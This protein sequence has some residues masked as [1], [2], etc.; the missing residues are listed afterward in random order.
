MHYAIS[1][2]QEI[3]LNGTVYAVSDDLNWMFSVDQQQLHLHAL[4]P[5]DPFSAEYSIASPNCLMID[6]N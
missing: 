4:D 1:S 6:G 5:D 2:L 3:S